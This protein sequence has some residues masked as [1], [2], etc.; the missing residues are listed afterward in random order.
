MGLKTDTVIRTAAGIVIDE[1]LAGQSE[2]F[3]AS[4]LL[5]RCPTL[6]AAYHAPNVIGTALGEGVRGKGLGLHRDLQGRFSRCRDNAALAASRLSD[7]E[8]SDLAADLGLADAEAL[9]DAIDRLPAAP[10][11]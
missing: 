11:A 10:V 9:I 5:E 1:C 8:L 6:A 7:D 4:A 3:T 2:G